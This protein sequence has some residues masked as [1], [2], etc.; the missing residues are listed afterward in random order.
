MWNL[1]FHS[2]KQLY[3]ILIP[4]MMMMNGVD[5]DECSVIAYC[6]T[7][8][9]WHLFRP[10]FP[11]CE[12]F[13]QP[14]GRGTSVCLRCLRC[15]CCD[16]ETNWLFQHGAPDVI[17]QWVQFCRAWGPLSLLSKLVRVQTVLLDTRLILEHWEMG[18][19]LVKTAQYFFYF[20]TYFN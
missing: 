4:M 14:T 3:D 12:I 15:L 18:V 7:T 10:T 19:V 1:S 11:I 6:K 16:G 13:V 2:R 9:R 8:S 20:P 5:A 17:V